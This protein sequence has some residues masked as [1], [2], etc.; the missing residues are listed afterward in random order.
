M[1]LKIGSIYKQKPM[2]GKISWQLSIRYKITKIDGKKVFLSTIDDE[3][4]CNCDMTIKQFEK[5]L[6]EA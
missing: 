2:K 4:P 6:I 3:F 1:E 5:Y